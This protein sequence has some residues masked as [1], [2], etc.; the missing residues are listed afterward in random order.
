MLRFGM[1]AEVMGE[2]DGGAVAGAAAE[3]PV[4][5]APEQLQIDLVGHAQ[6]RSADGV[7]E[8]FETAVDLAR[9]RAVAIVAAVE[10]VMRCASGIG[11]A[12]ILH[13]HEFGNRKTVVHFDE[14]D[15]FDRGF[16]ISA[17]A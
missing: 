6:A 14:V 1:P 7:A 8:A 12:E 2:A 5:G 13:Q 4:A 9:N 16:R 3:L 10:H 15:L 17:S 11:E